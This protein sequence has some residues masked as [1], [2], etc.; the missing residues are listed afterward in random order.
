[1][2]LTEDD[3]CIDNIRVPACISIHVLIQK[4]GVPCESDKPEHVH[5]ATVHHGCG[6]IWGIRVVHL[7][8]V[9]RVVHPC[10]CLQDMVGSEWRPLPLTRPRQVHPLDAVIMTQQTDFSSFM[11]NGKRLSVKGAETIASEVMEHA[12][13]RNLKCKWEKCGMHYGTIHLLE[14][15]SSLKKCLRFGSLEVFSISTENMFLR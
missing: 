15:V 13:R 10:R 14:R 12:T 5:D 2:P 11:L 6:C 8:V 9:V 4:F 3:T 7:H 1:M